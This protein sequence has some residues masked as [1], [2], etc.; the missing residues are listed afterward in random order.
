VLPLRLPGSWS[1]REKAP[2]IACLA[3]QYLLE[4]CKK[5]RWKPAKCD[6]AAAPHAAAASSGSKQAASCAVAPAAVPAVRRQ[7]TGVGQNWRRH[8]ATKEEWM[9]SRCYQRARRQLKRK[10]AHEAAT[11][12]SSIDGDEGSWQDGEAAQPPSQS[13]PAPQQQDSLGATP[14]WPSSSAGPATAIADRVAEAQQ[15]Q[16]LQ[17]LSQRQQPQGESSEAAWESVPEQP[18]LLPAN[19]P[20]PQASTGLL[21]LEAAQQAAAAAAGLTESLAGTFA[22]LLPMPAEQVRQMKRQWRSRL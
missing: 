1:P 17:G 5:P 3:L 15:Q 14:D 10:R 8:P 16:Q 6:C 22:A 11:A 19:M 9:C 20:P 2:H 21:V 12:A 4:I 18:G 13:P 7:Y